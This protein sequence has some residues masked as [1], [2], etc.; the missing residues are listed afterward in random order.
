MS[1]TEDTTGSKSG[2][3]AVSSNSNSTRHLM[4]S[5]Q[6]Q[7]EQNIASMYSDTFSGIA[8]SKNRDVAVAETETAA[9]PATQTQTQAQSQ[10]QLLAQA[11]SQP[12]HFL[13]HTPA[14]IAATAD[15]QLLHRLQISLQALEV[16]F[17][18]RIKALR[19]QQRQP[20]LTDEQ[21]GLLKFQVVHLSRWY[22]TE[23][24]SNALKQQAVVARIQQAQAQAQLIQ[25]QLLQQQQKPPFHHPFYPMQAQ[26]QQPQQQ[27]HRD[28]REQQQQSR[29][30]SN[31]KRRY[32]AMTREREAAGDPM[33]AHMGGEITQRRQQW[34][35]QRERHQ[36]TAPATA[37]TAVEHTQAQAQAHAQP[38]SQV[39][40][41]KQQAQS[42]PYTVQPPPAQP[43]KRRKLEIIMDERLRAMVPPSLQLRRKAQ[44]SFSN[45]RV[46]VATVKK[47]RNVP[48]PNIAPNVS[49]AES[50]AL[51][52]NQAPSGTKKRQV[53]NTDRVYSQFLDEIQQ[54]I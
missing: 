20:Q 42:K 39:T 12:G 26:A 35:H 17:Q 45:R 6:Q 40:E 13:S 11:L 53:A 19:E 29:D 23:K 47:K 43:Q 52:V 10:A 8:S 48:L 30:N 14:A 31:N 9:K 28:S 16:D 38:Q 44:P 7:M 24:Q 18:T 41:S 54:L 36:P 50:A 3:Q 21:S 1:K 46:G 51:A 25:Q 2:A 49:A 34:W 27:T 4:Q 5:F 15:Q 33:L 32:H 22:A 37:T